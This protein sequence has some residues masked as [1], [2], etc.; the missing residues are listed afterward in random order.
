VG[1]SEVRDTQEVFVGAFSFGGGTGGEC[2]EAANLNTLRE[3]KR[4]EDVDC[5]CPD[6]ELLVAAIRRAVG[7]LEGGEMVGCPDRSQRRTGVVRDEPCRL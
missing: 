3:A 4:E 6:P 2:F 1:E 5:F 7:G